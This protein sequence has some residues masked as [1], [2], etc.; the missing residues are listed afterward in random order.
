MKALTQAS[1]LTM[2]EM[3]MKNFMLWLRVA[4][5]ATQKKVR[6]VSTRLM[7]KMTENEYFVS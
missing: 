3:T 7:M 4:K 6:R 5:M 2:L 1:S